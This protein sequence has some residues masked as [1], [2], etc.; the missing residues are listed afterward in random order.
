MIHAIYDRL[1][2]QDMG[3]I[4]VKSSGASL[5]IFNGPHCAI[6]KCHM[7]PEEIIFSD[8]KRHP[9]PPRYCSAVFF[10]RFLTRRRWGEEDKIE[11]KSRAE[12]RKELAGD[13]KRIGGESIYPSLD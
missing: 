11:K 12:L 7:H 8:Q 13:R 10:P 2:S 6:S 3:S 5:L 1:V 9:S 4:F